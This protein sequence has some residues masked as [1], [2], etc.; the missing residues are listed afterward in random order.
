MCDW[1]DSWELVES[2]EWGEVVARRDGLNHGK[3]TKVTGQ[4][5][6]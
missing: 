1:P 5:D 4:A 2:R 3:E 6:G